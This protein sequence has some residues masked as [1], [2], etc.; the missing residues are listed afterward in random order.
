[1][2]LSHPHN[3]RWIGVVTYCRTYR[4]PG[5]VHNAEC[6]F[7]RVRGS[8]SYIYRASLSIADHGLDSCR[9]SYHFEA[10]PEKDYILLYKRTREP[11]EDVDSDPVNKM[12]IPMATDLI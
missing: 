10:V 5:T 4:V 3:D 7:T 9:D 8:E 2:N 6:H 12:S 1:M 11:P